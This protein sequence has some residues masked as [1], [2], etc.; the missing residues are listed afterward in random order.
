MVGV[1]RGERKEGL[2]DAESYPAPRDSITS[3]ARWVLASNPAIRLEAVP[4][5]E[6]SPEMNLLQLICPWSE[7]RYDLD[8]ARAQTQAQAQAHAQAQAQAQTSAQT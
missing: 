7:L 3:Y 1:G 4:L 2:S 8:L 6:F 5:V